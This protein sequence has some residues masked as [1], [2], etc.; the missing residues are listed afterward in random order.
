[1]E[2]ILE[3][4]YAVAADDW[5]GVVVIWNGSGTFEVWT[6][7][8]GVPRSLTDTFLRPVTSA[9]EAKLAARKWLAN[10]YDEMERY[11]GVAA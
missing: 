11:H 3:T 7:Y 8:E 6:M 9:W 2:S 1:M 5:M 4:G 10:Q